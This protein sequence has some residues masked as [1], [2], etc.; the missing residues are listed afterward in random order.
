[1][2]A[3]LPPQYFE[4]EKKYRQ[5]KKAPGKEP[6]LKNPVILKKGST[7]IDFA[8]QIHKDFVRKLRYARI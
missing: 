3:N 2:P 1:M 7:V 8:F 5:A 6:D 4:A